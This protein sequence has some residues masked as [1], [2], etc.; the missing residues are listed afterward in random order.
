MRS[1]S[2][3]RRGATL[4]ELM[5]VVSTL[6]IILG[7]TVPK[8]NGV[9]DRIAC[10][11]AAREI[12]LAFA[13]GRIGAI[14]RGQ[15]QQVHVHWIDTSLV[16]RSASTGDTTLLRYLGRVHGVSVRTTRDS[17]QF[18]INGLGYGGANFSIYVKRGTAAETVRVSREGRAR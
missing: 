1:L 18:A 7:I 4:V 9:L 5:L 8:F 17:T 6:A 13:Q 10:R 3:R 11:T 2:L 16:I 12:R 14:G 15:P